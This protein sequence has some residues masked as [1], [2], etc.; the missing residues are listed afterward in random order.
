MTVPWAGKLGRIAEYCL[1]C[2]EKGQDFSISSAAT[3]C[4]KCLKQNKR[5]NLDDEYL[6]KVKEAAQAWC[7]K[8]NINYK[9][10]VVKLLRD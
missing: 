1:C 6:N 9:E 3:R 4:I 5:P 10:E 8:N 2:G 7:D